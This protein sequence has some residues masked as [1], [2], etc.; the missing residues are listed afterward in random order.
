MST[1][2]LIN[3]QREALKLVNE[4]IAL[5]PDKGTVDRALIM[6]EKLKLPMSVVLEKLDLAPMEVTKKLGV[7]R[8]V[9]HNWMNGLYRPDEKMAKKLARLTGFDWEDIRGQRFL[10]RRG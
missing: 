2:N 5:E 10:R 7:H 8:N 9:Y 4:I 3:R 6:R 1:G